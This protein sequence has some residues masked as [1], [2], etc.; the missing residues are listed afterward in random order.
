[1]AFQGLPVSLALPPGAV[2]GGR[3][4]G[5]TV[6]EVSASSFL[7]SSSGVSTSGNESTAAAAASGGD[8]STRVFVTGVYNF[9]PD[10]TK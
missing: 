9:G 7:A 1:M 10:G 5:I 6:A 3:A 4:V 2:A 8:N